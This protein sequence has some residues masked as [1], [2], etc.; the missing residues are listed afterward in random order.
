MCFRS[1]LTEVKWEK[2]GCV[3]R[4]TLTHVGA[5]HGTLQWKSE[6][7]ASSLFLRWAIR[8]NIWCIFDSAA[9][10]YGTTDFPLA[11]GRVLG[12]AVWVAEPRVSEAD[13]GASL[14]QEGRG[15]KAWTSCLAHPLAR[16]HM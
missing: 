11:S 2:R 15:R 12:R 6:V 14:E 3:H 9:G 7:P 13:S 8:G 5:V 16:R 1:P 4:L 10:C